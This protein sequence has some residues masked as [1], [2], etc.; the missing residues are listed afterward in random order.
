[1]FRFTVYALPLL[2]VLLA[3]FGLVVELSGLEPREDSVLKLAV[4]SG[5]RVPIQVVLGAWILEATGLLSLFLLIQGRCGG[6]IL[7]GLVAGWLAWIFRG[8]LLVITIVVAVRQPQELW[9]RLAASWWVL[10]S[11]CGLALALL[12]RRT[13]YRAEPGDVVRERPLESTDPWEE[14]EP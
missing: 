1:M 2:F 4:T 3:L 10:Y 5:Q 7:D 11:L 6:W 12:W 9:W 13:Q 8:P 14:R